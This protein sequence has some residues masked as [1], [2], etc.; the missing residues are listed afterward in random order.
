MLLLLRPGHAEVCAP[1]LKLPPGE[2]NVRN[3]LAAAGA[4]YTLGVPL[5]KIAL[6][7]SRLT[8]PSGRYERLAGASG[9]TLIHDAYNASPSGMI[10]S[11]RTFAAEPERRI[12]LLGSMA[13]LGESAPASHRRLGPALAEV[14]ATHILVLGEFAEELLVGAREAGVVEETLTR[15]KDTEEAVE[16]LREWLRPGDILLVKG[17]RAYRLERVIE[18]LKAPVP[19]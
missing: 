19:V 4:A 18:A 5:A 1:L 8:L 17:S 15:V 13:E 11:L 2:H 12:V 9:I 7:A 16:L 10:A 6:A 3:F 14:G